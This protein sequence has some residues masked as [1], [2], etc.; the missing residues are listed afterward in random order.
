MPLYDYIYNRA[1]KSSD[2]LYER[3]RK[4]KKETPDVVHRTHLTSLQSLYHLRVGFA[5]LAARRYKSNLYNMLLWPLA[6]VSMALT[7]LYRSSFTVEKN[8]LLKI[9]MQTWAI[10]RYS[11]QVISIALKIMLIVSI[12]MVHNNFIDCFCCSVAP[13]GDE[14]E[15]IV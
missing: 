14:G 15:S 6:C 7:Y 13:H 10:P 9:N 4:G 3:S 1:D 12:L 8:K 11:F 2:E 5:S